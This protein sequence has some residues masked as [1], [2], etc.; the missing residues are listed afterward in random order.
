MLGVTSPEHR[1]FLLDLD[2]LRVRLVAGDEQACAAI[3]L[4]IA[5][6]REGSLVISL[7]DGHRVLARELGRTYCARGHPGGPRGRYHRVELWYVSVLF[8]SLFMH[9]IEPCVG[10]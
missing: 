3:T 9:H 5:W 2:A 10:F 6:L 7:V 1:A 4:G 8:R